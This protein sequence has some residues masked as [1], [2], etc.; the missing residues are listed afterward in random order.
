MREETCTE[1]EKYGLA[2]QGDC[3]RLRTGATTLPEQDP[4]VTNALQTLIACLLWR[5]SRT[6]RVVLPSVTRRT[7]GWN[8][9]PTHLEHCPLPGSTVPL[10]PVPDSGNSRGLI[11]WDSRRYTAAP[12]RKTL[13][14]QAGQIPDV[15]G[16]PFFIVMA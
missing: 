6:K 16:L 10:G 2:G 15:A 1:P 9:H 14:P 5:N 8:H 12:M 13:V 3:D 11:R 7:L 4:T